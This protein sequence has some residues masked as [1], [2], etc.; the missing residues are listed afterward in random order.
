[1]GG[2]PCCNSANRNVILDLTP[3]FDSVVTFRYFGDELGMLLQLGA[4]NM[5]QG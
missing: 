3:L 4:V 5:L 1:M 2:A